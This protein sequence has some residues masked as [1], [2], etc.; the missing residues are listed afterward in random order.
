MRRT[1]ANALSAVLLAVGALPANA[2]VQVRALTGTIEGHEV[3]G[4]SVDMTGMI[5]AADFGDIVWRIT[6]EGRRVVLARG[7][8]G[9]AG[10]AVDAK[11][12]LLQASFY[13]DE[14]VRVDRLGRVT[15]FATRGLSR[16]AGIALDRKSGAV[17]VTNCGNGTVSRIGPDGTV[18]KFAESDLFNCPYGAALDRDGNLYV[19]NYNDNRLTRIAPDGTVAPFATVS[20][21]G[22]S[23]LC[24][25]GDQLYVAAFRSH[26]VYRVT[27]AGAVTRILGDGTRGPVDGAGESARLSF[28]F[29][30][31]CHPWAPRLYLNEETNAAEGMLPRRSSI[32]VIDLKR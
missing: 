22:L 4:V 14:I 19:A 32:R 8:Y 29:G 18:S 25:K 31:G 10:N 21:K 2:Q 5:Y 3:G 1:I 16:P 30:I 23:H 28:P 9:T 24:F 15:P 7:L 17:F 11:G 13:A 20:D 27:M 26:A 12:N 6:P